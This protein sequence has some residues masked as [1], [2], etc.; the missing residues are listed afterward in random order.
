MLQKDVFSIDNLHKHKEKNFIKAYIRFMVCL[1]KLSEKLSLFAEVI[2][3]LKTNIDIYYD[4]GLDIIHEIKELLLEI[5]DYLIRFDMF[6]DYKDRNLYRNIRSTNRIKFLVFDLWDHISTM[7]GINYVIHVNN[8]IISNNRDE[9]DKKLPYVYIPN[10]DFL[11]NCDHSTLTED[12]GIFDHKVNNFDG[13]LYKYRE[14]RR[15]NGT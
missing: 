2:G 13:R 7:E 10:Y 8:D 11:L 14:H 5:D 1:S 15:K 4:N 6:L 12:F 9:C 3:N